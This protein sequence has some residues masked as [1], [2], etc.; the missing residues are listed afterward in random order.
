MIDPRVDELRDEH[1]AAIDE[2]DDEDDAA[3]EDL[4]GDADT[5]RHLARL[6]LQLTE[7]TLDKPQET[8]GFLQ[9]YRDQLGLEEGEG[10]LLSRFR[11]RVWPDRIPTT[12]IASNISFDRQHPKWLLRPV[13]HGPEAGSYAA[14]H[15]T[16]GMEVYR[17]QGRLVV[18][19]FEV[20]P[21][22]P[23]RDH[24]WVLT[25]PL[26]WNPS[27][28]WMDPEDL[29]VLGR[30][31][32][33]REE[34]SKR[35]EG[36][37]AFLSWQEERVKKLQV[38]VPYLGWRWID[39]HQLAF[40]VKYPVPGPGRLV[41]Q[42]LSAT[43][44]E[45]EKDERP[46]QRRPPPPRRREADPVPLGEVESVTGLDPRSESTG[47]AW[48]NALGSEPSPGQVVIRLDEDTAVRLR[49]KEQLLPA[50]GVLVSSIAGD[51][52]PLRNQTLAID[53]LQNSQ[54]FCPRLADFLF[55][56]ARASL[57]ASPPPALTPLAGTRPLNPGQDAAVTKALAA[58][59]LFL[60]QGPPGTGKTTVI[61]ELCLRV[62]AEGGRVLVASQTNLAVD[63]A[64]SRIADRPSIRRLRLG[65]ADKVD[66]D[67]QDFLAGKVVDRWFSTISEACTERIE[68]TSRM[69]DAWAQARQR[70]ETLR[71]VSVAHDEART[72]L[73]LLSE[74]LEDTRHRENTHSRQVR[75]VRERK[76]AAHHHIEVLRALQAW[77]DGVAEPPSLTAPLDL[78]EIDL[79]VSEARAL[80]PSRDSVASLDGIALLAAIQ[81]RSTVLETLRSLLG[82]GRRLCSGGHAGGAQAELA[83]LVA[84]RHRLSLSEDDADA[85]AARLPALNKKIKQ[86]Q[87]EQW[88]RFT[89]QFADSS[90]RGWGTPAPLP[91]QQ[92]MDSLQPGR[93]LLPNLDELEALTEQAQAASARVTRSLPELSRAFVTRSHEAQRHGEQLE[94]TA[95]EAEVELGHL[96]AER[97]GQL[98]RE[99]ELREAL[100]SARERWNETWHALLPSG[101]VAPPPEPSAQAVEAAAQKQ[102]AA[103]SEIETP[104]ERRK[105]WREVQQEW[106]QRLARVADSD[107][108]QLQALYIQHANVVGMTCNEAGKKWLFQAP[109][110]QPFDMVIIDEVSKA[111]PTELIMPMLL[112]RK[113][114]LVGDHRQLPPMFRER[115]SSF[116]EARAEGDI[117]AETFQKYQ[118]MVTASLF[119]ELFEAAPDELKAMLWTQYRMHPQVMDAVNQFYGGRLQPGAGPGVD[120]PREKLDTLRQHHL[121]IPDG[122]GGRLLEPHQHLLW[123]DSSRNSQQQPNWEEQRGSSKVNLLE[124]E[125]VLETLR[126]LNEAL[127]ARGYGQRLDLR[128]DKAE[129]GAT[130]RDFVQRRLRGLPDATLD[131]LFE[132]KRIRVQGRSQKA[133]R[134]VQAGETLHV[135]A[136]RQ[137]GVITF[138]GAQLKAL[139]GAIDREQDTLDA[140]EVRANTVD[141]FQG[142]ERPIIIASLVRSVRGSLGEFV[143]QFQRI[144]VGFSRA[145]ELLVI[146]GAAETFKRARIELP[147]LD[148][149]P[150]ETKP[151]YENIFNIAVRAGGRRYARQLLA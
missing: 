32:F 34:T 9:R 88:S 101:D 123:V 17:R 61:A 60:I 97:E 130:M 127:K 72:T 84:E 85:D 63:N 82:E 12:L 62:T 52:A 102:R 80:L 104:L 75:D 129:A 50:R 83:T 141:R 140:M 143:R 51:L 137:V 79:V 110:F 28:L 44:P 8:N 113:V 35:L 73:R 114:V 108:E 55:S 133:G 19:R 41:G 147:P 42:E 71:A 37:R 89:R 124:V 139:R 6:C 136:R 117:D 74:Q 107:R 87:G 57:P 47:N 39:E 105:R 45:Q 138:Y 70:L 131:D 149:G 13:S 94:V 76:E 46:D 132:E 15:Q 126:R 64:L 115:E 1:E 38:K 2:D 68:E 48:A 125:L 100:E 49:Q 10:S 90:S 86:L 77:A 25:A 26:F 69:E 99:R 93:E 98:T 65:N 23:R 81:R 56:A 120:N 67:Y 95:R 119:Q 134:K 54:G 3:D 116:A 20:T 21:H 151:I 91:A 121:T 92:L 11:Q 103:H 111:T 118:R 109:D 122:H 78:P 33:H 22:V 128:V 5:P 106:S 59:D 43:P 146:I 66:E 53:R 142:M 145:Q 16:L 24:E 135:D 18:K 36:W 30:L 14:A 7:S 148:G 58:P 144:N 112:G 27:E 150:L 4:E 31:P 29:N 40:L 96:R